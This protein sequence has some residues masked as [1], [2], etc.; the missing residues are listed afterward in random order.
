MK[1]KNYKLK[2]G[3]VIFALCYVLF[4]FS[5]VLA[6]EEDL[7]Y[8]PTVQSLSQQSGLVP[9]G[10][11][12]IKDANGNVQDV[13][14][15]CQPCHIFALG[16]NLLNFIW[17]DISIPIATIMLIYAGI[18]MIVPSFS[19]NVAKVTKGS[20]IL[21]NTLV[22]LLIV[23]L[24][25]LIIDTI[26]KVVAGQEINGTTAEV[27][28]TSGQ[29]GPWNKF[30]C[31][32]TPIPVRQPTSSITQ[33]TISG[34]QTMMS[35][36]ERATRDL[37]TQ[38]G[39]KINKDPCPPGKSY[40]QVAGGCTNVA[41]LPQEVINNLNAIKNACGADVTITGGTE[42][43]HTSHGQGNAIVDL[44]YSDQLASCMKNNVSKFNITQ[45][46][47]TA[48]NSKYSV[49]CKPAESQPHIHVQFVKNS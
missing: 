6:A 24:A 42:S 46:C 1:I 47:M 15:P 8:Q 12:T 28:Q 38:R 33:P 20:K 10:V 2:I 27:L 34:G 44:S 39:I 26:I 35:A 3:L 18:L 43:G 4:A 37:L 9:C 21:T 14:D 11:G 17:W 29:L 40:G 32:F 25:W 48:A 22:G 30:D 13:A 23:F 41:G 49:N 31:K 36:N 45:M 16:Q 5:F 7:Q 19:G